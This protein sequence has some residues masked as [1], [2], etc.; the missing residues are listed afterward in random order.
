MLQRMLPA[1]DEF[2]NTVPTTLVGLKV[3]L[4]TVVDESVNY[5]AV[6]A[7]YRSESLGNCL[8]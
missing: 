8:V 4:E 7:V 2:L 6:N 5:D 1:F 3:L